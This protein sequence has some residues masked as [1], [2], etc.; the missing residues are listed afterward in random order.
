MKTLREINEKVGYRIA[1]VLIIFLAVISFLIY[2]GMLYMG[3]PI[4]K[5]NEEVSKV[6]CNYGNKESFSLKQINLSYYPYHDKEGFNYNDFYISSNDDNINKILKACYGEMGE[7]NNWNVSLRLSESQMKSNIDTLENRGMDT[8]T[9][10]QY[11][12]LYK[13]DVTSEFILS[14][15]YNL[16]PDSNR[17]LFSI[18][19]VFDYN[20]ELIKY[21][22][23]GNLVIL[24]LY[25]ILKRTLYY[26]A[27]GT[28]FPK[29]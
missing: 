2:N 23:I 15:V 17:E 19:K 14:S 4:K 5:M 28:A 1:K 20:T 3:Y 26:I 25:E 12:N 6:V 10:Q 29:K 8:N 11:V 21:F 13:K 7:T 18:N 24:L 27:S 9:I 22:L 16:A